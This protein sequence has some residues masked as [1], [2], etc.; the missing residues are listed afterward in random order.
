MEITMEKIT[1]EVP[2]I[3][4]NHCVHTI[5]MELSE[6][7]GVRSVEADAGTKLVTVTFEAPATQAAIETLLAEINYPVKK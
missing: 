7:N 1:F 4:C 2:D 6:L 3:S 5:K